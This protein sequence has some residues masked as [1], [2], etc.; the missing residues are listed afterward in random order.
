MPSI[1]LELRRPYAAGRLDG[2]DLET[3]G[4]GSAR[5]E[6]MSCTSTPGTQDPELSEFNPVVDKDM[7]WKRVDIEQKYGI[8]AQYQ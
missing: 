7:F 1:R 2:S 6:R 3:N 8:R 4:S 5:M